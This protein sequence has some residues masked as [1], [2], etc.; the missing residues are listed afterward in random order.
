M[1]PILQARAVWNERVVHERFGWEAGNESEGPVS[2]ELAASATTRRAL[3]DSRVWRV[4]IEVIR[5]CKFLSAYRSGQVG[6]RSL[7]YFFPL[8][9]LSFH[10]HGGVDIRRSN[11]MHLKSLVSVVSDSDPPFVPGSPHVDALFVQRDGWTDVASS[12]ENSAWTE[13]SG[14]GNAFVQ[15]LER[16]SRSSFCFRSCNAQTAASA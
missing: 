15:I 3:S 8:C 16:I 7:S 11:R 14:T 5:S 12:W 13:A 1:Q 4:I 10:T 2:P 6:N 9:V